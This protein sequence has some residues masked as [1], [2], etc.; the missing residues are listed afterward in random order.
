ML[1][2][3]KVMDNAPPVPSLMMS[4]DAS[5]FAKKWMLITVLGMIE[6]VGYCALIKAC[7][8]PY[9]LVIIAFSHHR[10]KLSQLC[11]YPPI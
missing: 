11:P 10:G 8:D 2:V 3:S 9:A 4:G 7:L 5:F 1:T 6:D